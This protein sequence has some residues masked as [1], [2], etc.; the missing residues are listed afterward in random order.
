MNQKPS[1]VSSHAD[2]ARRPDDSPGHP[3]GGPAEREPVQAHAADLDLLRLSCVFRAD[4]L[5]RGLPERSFVLARIHRLF[6]RASDGAALDELLLAALLDRGK[7]CGENGVSVRDGFPHHT[8][9]GTFC[10]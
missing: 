6:D 8:M 10:V 5:L 4:A 3:G 9:R 7:G 1:V 2:P